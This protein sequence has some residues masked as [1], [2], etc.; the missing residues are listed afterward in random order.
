MLCEAAAIEVEHIC[1]D[2]LRW[3]G[4]M[5]ITQLLIRGKNTS[6]CWLSLLGNIYGKLYHENYIVSNDN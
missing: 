3:H 1:K 2:A 6:F 5:R 4:I